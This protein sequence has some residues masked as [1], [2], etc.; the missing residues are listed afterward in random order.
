MHRA[1]QQ[2]SGAYIFR[3][4]GTDTFGITDK[5]RVEI[6]GDKGGFQEARQVWADWLT[7]VHTHTHTH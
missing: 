6:I 4:N 2:N 5:V 3:P 7:Q 1:N